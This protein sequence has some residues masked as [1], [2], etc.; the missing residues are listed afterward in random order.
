MDELTRELLAVMERAA[1]ETD[2]R[3]NKNPRG[4]VWT[5][6][7]R[8]HVIVDG[9]SDYHNFVTCAKCGH[10]YCIA[11]QSEPARPCHK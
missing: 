9:S 10:T 8:G 2:K 11:C 3:V 1:I 6:D 7:S 4:H 5:K